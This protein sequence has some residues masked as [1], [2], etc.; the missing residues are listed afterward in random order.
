MLIWADLQSLLPDWDLAAAVDS[1]CK[2]VVLYGLF[3]SREVEWEV[4]AVRLER[5]PAGATAPVYGSQPSQ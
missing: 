1:Q 4:L 3:T 5:Q 2:D